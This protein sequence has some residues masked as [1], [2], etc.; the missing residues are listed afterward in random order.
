MSALL[1]HRINQLLLNANS[2]FP[3]EIK[4]AKDAV[5]SWR[6]EQRLHLVADRRDDGLRDLGGDF[7]DTGDIDTE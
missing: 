1:S 5:R 7:C 6:R 4:E 3:S 2:P